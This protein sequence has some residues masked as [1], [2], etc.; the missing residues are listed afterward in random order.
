MAGRSLSAMAGRWTEERGKG[1]PFARLR[2]AFRETQ[3]GP[4][5]GG[6]R[7][8]QR[9]RVRGKGGGGAMAYR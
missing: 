7:R 2:E 1:I 6:S 8:A 9:D 3:A 4:R 5:G